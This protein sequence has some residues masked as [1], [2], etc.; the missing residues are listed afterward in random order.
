MNRL[1]S[2][3]NYAVHTQHKFLLSIGIP[4]L[5]LAGYMLYQSTSGSVLYSSSPNIM[6]YC[7]CIVM[8]LA[9]IVLIY[10]VAVNLGKGNMVAV[11]EFNKKKD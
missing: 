5:I 8:G 11:A 10:L 7:F 6:F 2:N 1:L 9:F 4:L 3:S